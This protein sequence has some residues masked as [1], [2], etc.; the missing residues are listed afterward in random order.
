MAFFL[1]LALYLFAAVNLMWMQPFGNPPDEYNR[2]LIPQ[3]IATHLGLPNGYDESI[4]IGGYGF[5]YAFQPI[6]PYIMQGLFMRLGMILGVTGTGLL[7]MARSVNVF[8]GLC[9]AIVVYL[10]SK[11]LFDDVRFRYLFSFLITFLPQALF[12]HTYVN[13]DSCCMLSIAIILLALAKGCKNHFSY[14]SCVLL[15][16][17]II[18]CALSYYNAYGFI[19][20]SIFIFF[21]SFLTDDSAHFSDNLRNLIKKGAFISVIVLAGISW[22]FIRSAVLYNGDFLGLS[23]RNA[24]ALL[25]AIPEFHPDTR[26][27]WQNQ[28]YSFFDML[29]YSD[30]INLST[31]SFIGVFGAMT[32]VTSLW[33]YRFFKALFFLGALCCVLP[34]KLLK[35][36]YHEAFLPKKKYVFFVCNMIMCVLIP[37]FLSAYYSYATDYQPQGRYLLPALIPICYFVVV[38]Y[39]KAVALVNKISPANKVIEHLTTGLILLILA[40]VILCLFVTIFGYAYPYYLA[41]PIA[42]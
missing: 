11:E 28:G 5:S 31:I 13:T 40:I 1:Y 4:R 23:S 33:V 18:L 32:I 35:G 24:C 12:M 30:F 26:V 14:P 6:L 25:Y 10:L 3:Y 22:W 42:P 27:T 8:L 21:Y 34:R 38:G 9:M 2:F 17:G 7:M 36:A 16:T 41:N 37:C 39:E 29:R 20:S 15:S 19:L